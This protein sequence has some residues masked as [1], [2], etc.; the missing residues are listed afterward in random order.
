MNDGEWG[1][2]EGQLFAQ[3]ESL[4]AVKDYPPYRNCVR[5]IG[6]DR[7]AFENSS[8]NSSWGCRTFVIDID[9]RDIGVIGL[10]LVW[11]MY[12]KRRGQGPHLTDL[13]DALPRDR[14]FKV[15]YELVHDFSSSYAY[16]AFQAADP[17]FIR[18]RDISPVEGA[19]VAPIAAAG[20]VAPLPA[21]AEQ[22]QCSLT[23][24]HVGQGMCSV[25]HG[26][27][28]GY[29]LDAGA[30]TPVRRKQYLAGLH[31]DGKPFVNELGPLVAELANAA[32]I[33]SHPDSDHWRL[34]DWD[35]SVLAKVQNVFLPAGEPALA[36]S[37]PA[38]KPKVVGVEDHVFH[39]NSRNWLDVRRSKPTA[40][41]K[42]GECL[43][44][45]VYCEG[46]RGLLPGDYVYE[47]MAG[48][49][50]RA[51]VSMA[52]DRFD[53]V[54]VPHHG[55][56]ASA[57]QVVAPRHPLQSKAFFSAGTHTGYGHPTPVSVASHRR[58]DF[59]VIDDHLCRDVL[60]KRLLP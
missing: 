34:L 45:A 4:W 22:A 38:V 20:S 53:A 28:A 9:W 5:L 15:E 31:D 58:R 49:G 10:P 40:S 19:K 43:V 47:R 35:A 12:G 57:A 2:P 26:S 41:D 8:Y 54:V 24:F 48:D 56:E 42:N 18:V 29:I 14:W 50:N 51:I 27:H 36:F 46:R 44:T 25:F 7:S 23:A 55:D 6:V 33:V 32:A 17:S 21:I 11:A 3:L 13:E 1:V 37:A 30:G 16:P 59:V 39:L 52:L 60:G